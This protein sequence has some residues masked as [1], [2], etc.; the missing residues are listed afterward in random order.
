MDDI[1]P[2]QEQDF[3]KLTYEQLKN[4]K[5]NRKD[6]LNANNEKLREVQL[7]KWMVKTNKEHFFD[8]E[9]S[10]KKKIKEYFESLDGDKSGAIGTDEMEEPMLTLGIAKSK[11][12]VK[13]LMEEIDEDKSGQVEF[14]EFLQILKGSR[15]IHKTPSSTEN[16][17]EIM[18]FFKGR[19][20]ITRFR[21]RKVWG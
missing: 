2:Y 8:F 18:I 5:K 4:L 1:D 3:S 17:E 14:N 13:K 15:K 6:I 7:N 19:Y 10:Y 21:R 16:N 9:K 11:V 12:Q 20:I